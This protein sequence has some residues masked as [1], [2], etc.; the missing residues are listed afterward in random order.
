[1]SRGYQWVFRPYPVIQFP[2]ILHRFPSIDLSLLG[3]RLRKGIPRL[4]FAFEDATQLNL[5]SPNQA[6]AALKA[7]EQIQKL[8]PF[9][10]HG[11]TIPVHVPT[12]LSQFLLDLQQRSYWE[13]A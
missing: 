13:E 10:S 2:S 7:L 12:A 11:S 8:S 1:M 5:Q 6:A 9:E 3:F 4:F